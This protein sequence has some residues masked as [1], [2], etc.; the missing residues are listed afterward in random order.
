MEDDPIV[1]LA[2][3]RGFNAVNVRE[4]YAQIDTRKPEVIL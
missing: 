2:R 1:K 3:I 4:G